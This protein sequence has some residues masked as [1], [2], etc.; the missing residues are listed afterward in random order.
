MADRSPP[1]EQP[2]Q[3]ATWRVRSLGRSLA[4]VDQELDLLAS[5]LG[6]SWAPPV[7]ERV[8]LAR[9]SEALDALGR[10]VSLPSAPP[11]A[12]PPAVQ[13]VTIVEAPA[14]EA[15]APEEASVPALEAPR[16]EPAIVVAVEAPAPAETSS[17]PLPDLEGSALID[18]EP[19][20]VA[21]AATESGAAVAVDTEDVLVVAE[22]PQLEEPPL[23][24]V[25]KPSPP[26]RA[27]DGDDLGELMFELEPEL[28]V[29]A[30]APAASVPRLTLASAAAPRARESAPPKEPATPP[31][32]PAR[33]AAR[34][35]DASES[36]EIDLSELLSEG[37]PASVRPPPLLR[38]PPPPPQR[39]APPPVPRAVK[40]FVEPDVV[41]LI[42]EDEIEVVR[43]SSGPPPSVEAKA[44]PPPPV[45]VPDKNA[46]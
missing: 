41:E 22:P 36:L 16:G 38:P 21:P 7:V 33:A 15:V 19:V 2:S 40:Q 20:F 34:S 43:T 11:A 37:K 5:S 27:S 42:D 28:T 8:T 18:E 25:A 12:S 6:A 1:H 44:P 35:G 31:K 4:E 3:H 46:S 45:R 23:H 9:A 14:V 30:P 39:S 32:V 26:T 17:S 10:G 24:V 13:T 29:G